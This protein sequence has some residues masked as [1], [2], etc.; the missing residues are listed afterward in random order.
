M[1]KL[2][3]LI[4]K[5]NSKTH[6]ICYLFLSVVV[7]CVWFVLWLTVSVRL[8]PA[9]SLPNY[10]CP[11]L[12]LLQVCTRV[13]QRVEPKAVLHSLPRHP[14]THPQTFERVEVGWQVRRRVRGVTSA[15]R[16]AADAVLQVEHHLAPSE[17]CRIGSLDD[18][19]LVGQGHLTPDFSVS[20]DG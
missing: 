6:S 13:L 5:C 16:S 18:Q 20:R 12:R 3:N 11:L 10:P 15:I 4:K 17:R 14:G 2:H 19:V 9:T 7:V 1:R 8:W